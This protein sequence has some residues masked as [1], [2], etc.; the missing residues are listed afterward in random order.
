MKKIKLILTLFFISNSLCFA[1]NSISL[2]QEDFTNLEKQIPKKVILTGI[3]EYEPGPK[4]TT[5]LR[6]GKSTI[7][8][9]PYALN[10]KSINIEDY[11][12][13]VVE[14]TGTVENIQ[15]KPG[16]QLSGKFITSIEKIT[17]LET[18][19]KHN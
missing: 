10:N 19:E 15:K 2:I 12:D 7:P 13:K 1:E 3:L 17:I 5:V 11:Y 16:N 6:T 4:I 8:I 14:I 18:N 9:H